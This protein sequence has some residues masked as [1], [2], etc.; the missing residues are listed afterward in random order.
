MAAELVAIRVQPCTSLDQVQGRRD[1]AIEIQLKAPLLDGEAS[2]A[3]L[4]F[5]A[6]A[7]G[8]LP[9]SVVLVRGQTSRMKWIEVDGLTAQALQEQ[10]LASPQP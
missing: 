9:R 8:A 7:L 10:L 6:R 2:K 3:M 4:R 1:G 5:V